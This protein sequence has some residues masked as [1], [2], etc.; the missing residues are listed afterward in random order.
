MLEGDL[1]P[2]MQDTRHRTDELDRQLEESYQSVRKATPREW[3]DEEQSD[4]ER[5]AEHQR[6]LKS[7][8]E[9]VK[10]RLATFL[11]LFVLIRQFEQDWRENVFKR[12]EKFDP[13]TDKAIRALYS[14]WLGSCLA[15]RGRI[16]YLNRHTKLF[17]TDLVQLEMC[18]SEAESLLK[19]WEPPVLSSAPSLRTP[20]LSPET[21]DNIRKLFPGKV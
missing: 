7:E 15:I 3:G 16:E 17:Q 8:A 4:E 11:S 6:Y 10:P 5:P 14:N 21:M 20:P 12:R 2:M 19:Y 1:M 9:F 18:K 13:L